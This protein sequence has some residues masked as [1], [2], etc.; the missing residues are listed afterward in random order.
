MKLDAKKTIETPVV[1]I[2]GDESALRKHAVEQLFEAA[3]IQPD[4]FDLQ[5]FEGDSDP[6]DWLASVGTAPFLAERRTVVVRH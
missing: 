2:S 1:L 5:I 4:D 6:T 3:N